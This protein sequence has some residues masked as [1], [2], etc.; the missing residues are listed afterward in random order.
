[1]SGEEAKMTL[2]AVN[3]LLILIEATCL[4]PDNSEQFKRLFD[5][6]HKAV[7]VAKDAIDIMDDKLSIEDKGDKGD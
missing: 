7:E 5:D 4:T 3:G 6:Y 2:D 1:M